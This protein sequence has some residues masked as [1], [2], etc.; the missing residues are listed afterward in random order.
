MIISNYPEAQEEAVRFGAVYGFGKL[1][2]LRPE[3]IERVRP[4]LE[5][6]VS[7]AG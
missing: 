7:A 6:S 4:F 2:L 5:Q 1:E 3:A